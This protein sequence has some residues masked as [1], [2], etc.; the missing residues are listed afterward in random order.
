M[1]VKMYRMLS[2]VVT[3]YYNLASSSQHVAE[4]CYD[5]VQVEDGFSETLV[6][7]CNLL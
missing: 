4:N 7:A 2:S 5:P 3:L 6:M 1:A